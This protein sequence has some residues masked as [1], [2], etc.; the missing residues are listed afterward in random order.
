MLLPPSLSFFLPASPPIS[1]HLFFLSFRAHAHPRSIGRADVT[2]A[3]AS[4]VFPVGD[5]L[6]WMGNQWNSGLLETP[7]GPRNHDLLYWDVLKFDQ[8]GKVDQFVYQE[9]VTFEI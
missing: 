4:A 1:P 5:Q 9:T 7:P 2:K 8:D 3:Q 6:I